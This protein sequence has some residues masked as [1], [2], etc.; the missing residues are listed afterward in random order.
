[1]S[2]ELLNQ[3]LD[4]TYMA[5]ERTPEEKEKYFALV[6]RKII[7]DV[8]EFFHEHRTGF[9]YSVLAKRYQRTVLTH[10]GLSMGEL[11][12]ELELSGK[13]TQMLGLNG[14]R[15]VVPG[16]ISEWLN[17]DLDRV[18]KFKTHCHQR[19][20]EK[21]GKKIDDADRVFFDVLAEMMREDLNR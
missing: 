12:D 14:S 1:M 4:L 18:S 3:T 15:F 7:A 6:K 2:L 20:L 5:L 11:F 13:I 19:Q 10:F 17:Q 9:P 21:Q 16:D 8:N